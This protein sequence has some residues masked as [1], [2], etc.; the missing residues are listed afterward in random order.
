VAAH[1]FGSGGGTHL[2]IS[3]GVATFP[4]DGHNRSTLL[5]MAD[6]AMYAAKRLGRNQVVAVGSAALSAMQDDGELSS[7]QEEELRG[8]VEALVAMVNE[9]EHQ[10]AA[11]SEDVANLSRRLA[12]ALGCDEIQA[13]MIARAGKLHDIGKVAVP[14]VILDKGG[15]L[16]TGE[17]QQIE[18]HPMIG[19]EVVSRVPSLRPV[20]PLIRSHHERWDG[21][22][23]PEGL[24]G[25]HIP[26]GAR[27]I[28]VADAFSAMTSD[29]PYREARPTAVAL[30]ELRRSAGT[31]FDPAAVA[32]FEQVLTA[33]AVG[34]HVA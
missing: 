26:L 19:A 31:Q 13:E 33:D 11:H 20:A 15:S 28:A 7:R 16:N 6:R 10:T 30:E 24:D 29:R 12:L 5:E 8:T 27:I 2:T 32:A 9:R 22:G 14:D 4:A 34:E 17:W 21:S 23:Y 1:R 3:V 18:R 25:T